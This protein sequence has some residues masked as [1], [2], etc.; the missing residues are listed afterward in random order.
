M[1]GLVSAIYVFLAAL[2]EDVDARHKAGHDELGGE[3]GLQ[4][5]APDCA[6]GNTA[7][8]CP[9]LNRKILRFTFDPN[10][11]YIAPVP[12]HTEGRFAIVTDVGQEMRWTRVAL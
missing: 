4:P 12:A 8:Q 7:N 3:T 9:A 10:H 6:S 11:F 2:P 1:A 5:E